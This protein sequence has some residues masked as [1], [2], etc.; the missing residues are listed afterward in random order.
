MGKEGILSDF[1]LIL[2]MKQGSDK[3]FE[4]FIR[5][6]YPE[7]LSFCRYH[8]LKSIEAE[9][10]TQET[11]LHFFRSIQSYQ[12]IG[13]TKNYLYVIAGNICKNYAKK[14]KAES[15]D[16]EVLEKKLIF[17][18]GIKQQENRLYVEQA[19]NQ[20]SSELREIII[21]IYF[22]GCK[23]SEVADILK[24]GLPLVKYRHKKAKEELKRLLGEEEAHELGKNNESI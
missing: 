23:L 7:I 20:L 14:K 4:K 5:K 8:S 16:Q 19:L 12:H 10:L 2:Q 6:Y 3:A 21:L 13:K 18:G 22:Q 9:D 11:F 24:I 17:D 1:L 15:I